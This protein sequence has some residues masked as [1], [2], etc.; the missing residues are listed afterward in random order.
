[1]NKIIFLILLTTS[2]ML[3]SN[4]SRSPSSANEKVVLL[5]ELISNNMLYTAQEIIRLELSKGRWSRNYESYLDVL[6]SEVGTEQLDRLKITPAQSSRSKNL[7]YLKGKS[8]LRNSDYKSAVKYLN[9]SIKPGKNFYANQIFLLASAQ[10]LNGKYDLANNNFMECEGILRNNISKDESLFGDEKRIILDS[11]ILNQARLEFERGNFYISSKQYDKIKK[12]SRVW[13]EILFE[14]AWSSFYQGN[15][16][17]TLG[18]LVTYR[19]PFFDFIFNPEVEVLEALSYMEICYFENTQ[20]VVNNF[21]KKYSDDSKYLKRF[22]NKYANQKSKVGS[23]LINVK[24]RKAIK[25]KLLKRIFESINKDLVFKRLISNYQGIR[26]ELKLVKSYPKKKYISYLAKKLKVAEKRQREL[27]GSYTLRIIDRSNRMLEKSFRG[28]S[29]IRLEILKK[30]KQRF[31][32]KKYNTGKIGELK[33]VKFDSS[34]YVWGFNGEFWAD[35]LGD[36]VFSL[37]SECKV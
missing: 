24:N 12:S 4:V 19:S 26:E 20:E 13:P 37:K 22:F 31:F 36:Y 9:K 7:S 32:G 2:P 29:Y 3:F 8:S 35:E 18:K 33:N 16:N 10:M 30:E 28:M 25:N 23:L 34:H 21:Y 14:Q 27:I 6:F 5:E 15:Y 1:L 17:R 11:C